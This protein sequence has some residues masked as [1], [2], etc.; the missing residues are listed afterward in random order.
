MSPH[1]NSQ[2]STGPKSTTMNVNT[3]KSANKAAPSPPGRHRSSEHIENNPKQAQSA[4]KQDQ[5]G[6]ITQSAKKQD[7]ITQSCNIKE[8]Q[9][10][11][12]KSPDGDQ[13]AESSISPG[14]VLTVP[15]RL[16]WRR[17]RQGRRRGAS[18]TGGQK[19]VHPRAQSPGALRRDPRRPT[20]G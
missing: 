5:D 1:H 4:K 12:H 10:V 8:G 18:T 2:P 20:S 6:H 13:A 3:N 15:P 17:R 7:H 14:T 11:T 16:L 9:A 19:A